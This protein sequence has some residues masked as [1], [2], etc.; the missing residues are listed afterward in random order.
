MLLLLA[1]P[2]G[3]WLEG[4]SRFSVQY[5]PN[6]ACYVPNMYAYTKLVSHE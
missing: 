2:Q 6:K 1:P 3:H 4:S 5:V